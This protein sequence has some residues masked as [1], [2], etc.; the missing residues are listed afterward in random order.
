MSL[1]RFANR[2]PVTISMITFGMILMGTIAL[3]RLPMELMPNV[4]FSTVTIYLSIRGGMPPVEVENLVTRPIEEAMGDLSHLR[5]I[6]SLSEEGSATV[7]ISFEPGTNMDFAAL[8]VREKFNRI[9]N[10]LPKDVEK[11]VIA[12]YN[13]ADM[14]VMIVS[15]VSRFSPELIRRIVE[16]SIKPKIKR[17]SGVANV[18]LVGG[19]ER[20][21]LIEVDQSELQ[22]QGIPIKRIVEIINSNNL[23]LLVGDVKRLKDKFLI[24]V[25]G[26]FE[27]IEDIENLGIN[28]SPKGGSLVRLKNIA[29]VRD[30]FLDPTGFSR[31]NFTSAVTIYVQKE[32]TAN[33]IL[34]TDGIARELKEAVS[35]LGQDLSL[36]T[37]FNQGDFI[38]SSVKTVRISLIFGGL[39]AVFVLLVFLKNLRAT[40]IVGLSIPCCVMITFVFMYLGKLSLNIMTLSGLALG[41]GMIV[42]SSVVVLENV[43]QKREKGL[44]KGK[45][46][47]LGAEEMSR[48]IIA[49]TLTTVVVIIPFLL[50]AN[51]KTRLLYS[52]LG[53]T[54]VFA[55]LASLFIALT[56]V[57]MLCGRIKFGHVKEVIS[58]G[59]DEVNMKLWYRRFLSFTLR[60]RFLFLILALMLF[61]TSS[62][63][64]M[65]RGTELWGGTEEKEFTVYI[66]MPTGTKLSK[67][68]EVVKD[69][70]EML[71]EFPEVKTVT[72]R[73]KPWS[74][75][76]NVE[77]QPRRKRRR[78]AQ[79]II[80]IL[81]KQVES[82]EEAFIYF[83][84]PERMVLKEL[85][86]DIY[87]HKY[88]ELKKIASVMAQKMEGIKGLTD[89]RLRMRAPRPEIGVIV[90]RE[91]ALI[92]GFSVKD[93]AEILHAQLRGLVPT[94]YHT[95]GKEVETIVRLEKDD[96][97]TYEDLTR[98]TLTNPEG[99]LIFLKQMAGF[100]SLYGPSE[101]WRKNKRR[102]IQVTG[103]VTGLPMGSAVE[104]VQTALKPVRL[105][106][107]YHYKIAGSYEEMK[108][109]QKQLFSVVIITILLIYMVL[110][111]FFESFWQP[112]LI[113][114]TLPL[115]L[116]GVVLFLILTGTLKS[117]S[118]LIGMIMLAGI[119]VNNAII[120][121]AHINDLRQTGMERLKAVINAGQD[122]L[123]PILI[124]SLTTVIG[125]LP[126]AMDRSEAAGL[127]SPLAITVIGG[128][129][130]STILT[131][132]FLPSFYLIFD[133]FRLKIK[134]REIKF[135]GKILTKKKKIVNIP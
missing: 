119:S 27:S 126:M 120:F 10:K 60:F 116:I 104:K 7:E 8:E 112:L 23:N 83:K 57:P 45:A 35:H 115:A 29:T 4:G 32:S 94:R 33:T 6:E 50:I 85:T 66:E 93:V 78:S 24:R 125:L 130:V 41:V 39:L 117:V 102:M 52:S 131:L 28:I 100:T 96:R 113:M 82:I 76:I 59:G 109:N 44:P 34:V 36:V 26:Q 46:A 95:K 3:T 86:I 21:I 132:F 111:A 1:S 89:V 11:P 124:T 37:V 79:E 9:K 12:R 114:T 61:L 64:F 18:E 84:E 63:V 101:I 31:T 62:F 5:R 88:E 110:A 69:I 74:P 70:E 51:K 128:L 90:D 73:V 106:E 22:A 133:D 75:R 58:N 129:S 42:D 54:I 108:E 38:R 123:R 17:I 53:F 97:D 49:S 56:L 118:V 30:F 92:W 81:R 105:P 134:S 121:L 103:T 2:R 72:S 25:S 68:D 107:K 15:V 135:L 99:R 87:G 55:L 19:R 71:L 40:A 48:A 122:R 67:S 80:D 77:L 98:L 20:K 47:I 16:E 43:F 13:Y 65:K 91:K 14:P 127:W